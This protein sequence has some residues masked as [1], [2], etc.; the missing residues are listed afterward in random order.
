MGYARANRPVTTAT[1]LNAFSPAVVLARKQAGPATPS[2][3]LLPMKTRL[4][5][6]LQAAE[7]ALRDNLHFHDMDATARAHMQ[8]ALCHL[9]ESCIALDGGH[10]RS[11]DQLVSEQ[12]AFER[13][14]AAAFKASA[15]HAESLA[16]A[17]SK[18]VTNSIHP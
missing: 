8:R 18:R 11:V 17:A 3:R 6:N 4:L 12:A 16:P 13:L 14:M 10:A 1:S 9:R 15:Q 7:D 2:I 5:A